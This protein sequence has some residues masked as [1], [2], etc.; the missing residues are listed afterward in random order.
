MPRRKITRG[1]HASILDF[2]S[3]SSPSKNKDFDKTREKEESTTSNKDVYRVREKLEESGANR[4]EENLKEKAGSAKESVDEDISD[5][6]SI[7][8]KRKTINK[9]PMETT[10]SSIE[11]V[12]I[13]EISDEKSDLL[14]KSIA[15]IDVGKLELPTGE[16]LDKILWEGLGKDNVV[17]DST[18][19]CTDGISVGEIYNDQYGFKRQRG[20]VNTT[21]LPV[22]TDWIVEEGL[23]KKILPRAYGLKTNRGAVAL[24]PEDFLC[25][26]Q[27]R[28]G[29]VLLNYDR[30][31]KYKPVLGYAQAKTSRRSRKKK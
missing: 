24:I 12:P 23:V 25:E 31:T 1:K 2:L 5:L 21:R 22:Y 28:Y 13:S 9:S 10:S 18:G 7:L 8:G 20:Y 14:T 15:E 27:A 4:S 11:Q 29:V 3:I 17:C 16:I 19:K 26:L 6:L 30:C